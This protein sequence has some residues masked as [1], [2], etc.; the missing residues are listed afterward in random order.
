MIYR[1]IAAHF[2]QP[3]PNQPRHFFDQNSIQDLADSIREHGLLQ[4]ITVRPDGLPAGDAGHDGWLNGYMIIAG[5][6][7]FK[8]CALAGLDLIPCMVM[9]GVDDEKAFVLATLENVARKDMKPI[10]EAKAYA[11]IVAM[12]RT[13]EEVARLVGKAT[14]AVTWRL[15]LLNL[16]P[17]Y[18]DIEL[19]MNVGRLLS[20]VSIDG[21][22][23]I[24][25]RYIGGE[26]KTTQ[27]AEKYCNAVIAR[28]AQADL[29]APASLDPFGDDDLRRERA[30]V[31]RSRF[32]SA[33][34]KVLTIAHSFGP[35]DELGE[36]D[37]A[38]AL[39]GD[40]DRILAE[41]RQL[42]AHVRRAR[43]KLENAKALQKAGE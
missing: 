28:E 13:P 12:G 24:M 30:R 10:E 21:Q 1:E 32:A 18:Q 7:R 39:D 9:E 36:Q 6:R 35:I 19:P 14:F 37:A 41:M 5:E 25:R 38:D 15:E 40:I 16:A 3:N 26:F 43:I 42:E 20:R 31:N 23:T 34:E 8:A 2:I 11:Q 17:E 22:R 27:E 33:W 29:F 4:P